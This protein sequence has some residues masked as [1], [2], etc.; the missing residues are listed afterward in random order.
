MVLLKD[1]F[2]I[3]T[4]C[5]VIAGVASLPFPHGP[6]RAPARPGYLRY[7]LSAFPPN[8]LP[9]DNIGASANTAKMLI[10]RSL[11]AWDK[12]GNLQ[13]ELARPGRSM[14]TAPRS[15]NFARTRCFTTAR[16]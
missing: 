10:H 4:R 9:R 6:A 5:A 14:M 2:V 13:G 3:T 8:L 16:R 15:F 1:A 11:V 7:G 12:N